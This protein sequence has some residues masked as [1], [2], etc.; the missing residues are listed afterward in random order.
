MKE[1]K[2]NRRLL[3]QVHIATVFCF[4]LAIIIIGVAVYKQNTEVFI[5]EKN[6][7]METDMET[8]KDC[9]SIGDSVP[10][11]LW[12]IMEEYP[13]KMDDNLTEEDYD[14]I[15]DELS[16]QSKENPDIEDIYIKFYEKLENESDEN[17]IRVAKMIYTSMG[18]IGGYG[19]FML[20]YSRVCYIDVR[21]EKMWEFFRDN[22]KKSK[23]TEIP[24]NTINFDIRDITNQ[25]IYG[26]KDIVYDYI[27][28]EDNVRDNEYYSAYSIMYDGDKPICLVCMMYDL[29]KDIRTLNSRLKSLIALGTVFLLLIGFTLMI[30]LYITTL[31]PLLKI[32]ESVSEYISNKD[33]SIVTQSMS[34]IKSRNEIGV[35]ADDIARLAVE[36]DNYTRENIMLAAEKQ[37]V[38]TELEL[39][40]KIQYSMLSRDFP[41]RDE[42]EI[43]ASM[44]P[45]KEVGGD[46]YDFFFI[47]ENHLALTIADV[48]GKGIPAALFMM[49]SKILLEEFAM[50]DISPKKA[51]ERLNNKI[52]ENNKND[53]FVT[54]WLGVMDIQTGHVIAA[55]AGH[56]YPIV[57]KS[58]GG[59]ELFKDKH[60]LVV[61]AMEGIKYR[62][63]E[64]DI[65]KNGV[66]FVY[67]DGAAEATNAQNE[68]FR[69]DRMVDVLNERPSDSPEKLIH[70]MKEKIDEFVGDA[71][72]FDD[73][74]MLCI[75]YKGK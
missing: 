62:E 25:L 38:S 59:F 39:A 42:F 40:T 27:G 6:R 22:I 28:F 51:L 17:K 35:L 60:G 3:F 70:N 8:L 74:T 56:E 7:F 11:C 68:L 43:Y 67:T 26:G 55:N 71:P 2:K 61:G 20:E 44:T 46:F 65:E 64:F 72:Q 5:Q 52:S 24:E 47:D 48:S 29:T 23:Q 75:K 31:N 63:Y 10:E 18:L 15:S 54:V 57:K 45:A 73:L 33:T 14:Y 21:P 32:K 19:E 69:T 16:E 9:I 1:I 37:R 41:K 53:M 36:M 34:K 30:F 66:L 50:N 4:I 12:D 49:M 58:E 13:E